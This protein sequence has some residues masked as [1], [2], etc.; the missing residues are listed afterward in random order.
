MWMKML[1]GLN[2]AILICGPRVVAGAEYAD[3][4]ATCV[5]FGL[6]RTCSNKDIDRA[7]CLEHSLRPNCT[8]E[9]FRFAMWKEKERLL[10]EGGQA[11]PAARNISYIECV[12]TDGPGGSPEGQSEGF[13][14]PRNHYTYTQFKIDYAKRTAT[15]S[16]FK[17]REGP[18]FYIKNWGND[19]KVTSIN[20]AELMIEQSIKDYNRCDY[21]GLEFIV[22]R[23]NGIASMTK[24]DNGM[25]RNGAGLCVT[26]VV[27]N[28]LLRIHEK[29]VPDTPWPEPK[30]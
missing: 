8:D 27:S 2:A 30:F 18:G 5:A 16:G 17:L 24:F 4:E 13:D 20:D 21:Y 19:W 10:K 28:I 11:V 22:K 3:R 6:P 9:E 25:I 12:V 29:C 23:Q 7:L 15:S 14:G 1:L 26:D